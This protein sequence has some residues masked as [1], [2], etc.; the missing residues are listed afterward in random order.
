S[1]TDIWDTEDEFRFAY[2][3]LVG[4]GEIIA[5]VLDQDKTDP[6]NK[7]GIMARET[8]TP[9]SR[10]AFIALTSG[11]GVA[12]QNR[13]FTD[14]SSNNESTG[15][16]II[17][18]Y[19]LKLKISGNNYSGYASPDGVNWTQ[20]GSTVNAGFGNGIPIYAGLAI[21]SHD[22]SALSTA[23][24]NNYT[25]SGALAVELISFSG[26]LNLDQTVS[27]QWTTTLESTAKKFI[28][29]RSDDD[30]DFKDIDSAAA[31]TG[32][33][34]AL[35]YQS[36]DKHPFTGMNYYRLRIV[37]ADGKS[38][39]S[40]IVAIKVANAKAPKLYPNPANN[41]VHIVAGTEAIK[42]INIFDVTGKMIL[43]I[44]GSTMQT[45]MDI[46]IAV[47]S[48]GIYFVEITTMNSVFSE[49]LLIQK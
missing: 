2:Q 6:W 20:I 17:A 14:G 41:I 26:S 34:F 10:H 24:I 49:K 44:P 3:T 4:D 46:P 19:W 23:H 38:S 22:N 21:T 45:E 5:Q 40:A 30:I 47:L 7:A 32:G 43:R 18:P 12:F 33:R 27:L 13:I 36:I 8:L 11:N 48:N 42:S 29:E 37:D 1:G 35:T 16:G 39:Y 15:A 25:L 9:G 28:V 31:Q